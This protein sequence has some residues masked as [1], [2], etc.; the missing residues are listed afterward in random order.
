[1][2]VKFPFQESAARILNTHDGYFYSWP[3]DLSPASFR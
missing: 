1:M 2:R 3:Y